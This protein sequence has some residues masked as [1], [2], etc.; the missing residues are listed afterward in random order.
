MP[1]VYSSGWPVVYTQCVHSV[2]MGCV[3]ICV[4][5]TVYS[6]WA[7][8]STVCWVQQAHCENERA[9]G[10]QLLG[11]L[12][13]RAVSPTAYSGLSLSGGEAGV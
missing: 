9:G 11:P 13:C 2:C 10:L 3:N 4:V 7:A 6:V 12:C 1:G 5:Y 8:V